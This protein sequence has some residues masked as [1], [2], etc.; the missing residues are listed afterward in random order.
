MNQEGGSQ[1]LSPE[2]EKKDFQPLESDTSN[3]VAEQNH[4]D[5]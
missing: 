5:A 4:V 1:A 3:Q 2:K